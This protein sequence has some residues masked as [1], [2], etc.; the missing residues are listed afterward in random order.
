MV[1]SASDGFLFDSVN[2]ISS[3]RPLWPAEAEPLL[4]RAIE[5]EPR[6]K[7]LTRES[8]ETN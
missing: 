7:A 2:L 1:S 4:R 3:H 8:D 5:L 6:V